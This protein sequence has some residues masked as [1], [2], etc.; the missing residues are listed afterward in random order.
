MITYSYTVMILMKMSAH[1]NLLT[2]LGNA[3]S[4]LYV[5]LMMME[6]QAHLYFTR[7]CRSDAGDIDE[8]DKFYKKAADIRNAF[9]PV[10]ADFVKETLGND[11]SMSED[12]LDNLLQRSEILKELFAMRISRQNND[13]AGWI[14]RCYNL[15]T[16]LGNVR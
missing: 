15:L 10:L 13:K 11:N 12:V 14:S 7:F 4:M 2:N 8:A 6:S 16:Y 5:L 3:R 1:C 9:K